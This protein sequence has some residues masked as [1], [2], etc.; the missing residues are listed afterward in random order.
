MKKG[1]SV[2]LCTLLAVTAMA[3]CSGGSTAENTPNAGSTAETPSSTSGDEKPFEIMCAYENAPGE[4]VD[5]A[6]HYWKEQLEEISGGKMTMTLYPS[7][8]MGNKNEIIDMAL[9]GDAII[10]IGNDSF[11]A[12]LGVKDFNV[13]FT[14]FLMQ[15]W[16]DFDTI[17]QSDWYADQVAQLEGLGL[18]IVSNNWHYGA[19]QLLSKTPVQTMDDIKGMKVRTPNSTAEI[20]AFVAMGANPTP[21]ALSEVYT[22]LQQGTIDAVENPLD[23]LE[24]N[25][26]AEVVTNLTLTGHV[27]I[28]ASWLFSEQIF[29]GMTAEQQGWLLESGDA[30]SKYFNDIAEEAVA[31]ALESLQSQGCTVYEIDPAEWSAASA[32]FAELPDFKNNWSEGLYENIL[33]TLGR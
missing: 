19:R 27:Y 10:T 6:C 26:F 1:L 32:N 12:D 24:K 13:T 17:H 5:L 14:P 15:S 28:N 21:M 8:A 20:N 2:L 18:H 31:Q 23:V 3:G 25:A 33:E 29:Q 4:T 9:A 22:S 11:Y 30:A 7:S 16:E